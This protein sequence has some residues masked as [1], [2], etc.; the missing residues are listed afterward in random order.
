MTA[1]TGE[2]ACASL[3]CGPQVGR[4]CLLAGKLPRGFHV[5]RAKKG[6]CRLVWID[7][8]PPEL[9]TRVRISAGPLGMIREGAAGGARC[10]PHSKRRSRERSER[11]EDPHLGTCRPRPGWSRGSPS[12]DRPWTTL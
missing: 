7:F 9:E 6:A 4:P 1:A 12:R 5:K 8:Q 10:P 11:C 2:A 3:K